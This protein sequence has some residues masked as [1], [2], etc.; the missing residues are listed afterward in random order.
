VFDEARYYRGLTWHRSSPNVVKEIQSRHLHRQPL[1][2]DQNKGVL[3]HTIANVMCFGTDV[4]VLAPVA[5]RFRVQK[6]FLEAA[7][8]YIQRKIY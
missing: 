4:Q 6:S 5:L 1:W 2:R 8:W 7:A 3:T